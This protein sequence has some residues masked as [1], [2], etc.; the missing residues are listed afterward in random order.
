MDTQ[1]RNLKKDE[2]GEAA[3]IFVDAFNSVS[4]VQKFNLSIEVEHFLNASQ[5]LKVAVKQT[6]H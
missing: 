5:L 6:L 4:D 1:I 2:L 3:T